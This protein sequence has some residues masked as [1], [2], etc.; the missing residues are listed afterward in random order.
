MN[1]YDIYNIY[2]DGIP[3]KGVKF[4]PVRMR[5]Y[6]YFMSYAECLMLDKNSIPD[7]KVIS[8]KY[9]EYMY[10]ATEEKK[11]YALMFREL[12]KLVC[13]TKEEREER[14]EEGKP[15]INSRVWMNYDENGKPYFEINGIRFNSDDFDEVKN[16][17]VEQNLLELPDDSIQKGIREK[18]REAQELRAR[19]SGNRIASLEDQMISVSIYSGWSLESV[20]GMT[21]RKFLKALQ[22]ADLLLHYQ[23]YLGASMSGMVEFKDKSFIKHW[24]TE[25]VKDRYDGLIKESQ[26]EGEIKKVNNAL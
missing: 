24:L 26:V 2:D 9:L 13:F 25:I 7:V 21:V 10:Y 16:I 22:R 12:L 4:F 1:K 23:I 3:Y 15:V 8:M 14:D 11:P 20:Y 17:I 19:Q 6:I 18:M 5:D